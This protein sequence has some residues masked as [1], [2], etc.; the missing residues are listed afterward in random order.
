MKTKGI[1]QEGLKLIACATML[2]DHIGATVVMRMFEETASAGTGGAGNWLALYEL[3]RIIGRLAF[4]IYCFLLVEGAQRTRNPK[5]YGLRLLVG[6]LLSEIPFDMA[7]YGS[8]T[9][10]HQNVM[11]TLLL[12][13]LALRSMD[14]CPLLWQKLLVALPFGYLAEWL[15]SDYG[16]MGIMVMVL[17]QLTR[18]IPWRGVW[19]F[20]G[21]W[22]VFSPSH[23]LFIN[24]LGGFSVTIQEWAVLALIPI[25]CYNGRKLTHSKTAQWAFYLFYPVHILVLAMLEMAIFG[26]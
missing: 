4:P 22:M 2:L 11:V 23:A 7:F 18:D 21:L 14:R 5:K 20:F 10:A 24:W 6:V 13:F 3:L 17:F 9:W 15:S 19:Q 12:G 16:A 26:S 1:S 8:F 25:F